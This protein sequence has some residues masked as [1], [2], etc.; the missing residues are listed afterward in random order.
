MSPWASWSRKKKKKKLY[1]Q[2]ERTC[3]PGSPRTEKSNK[4]REPLRQMWTKLLSSL[5]AVASNY[6]WGSLA[7]GA[8]PKLPSMCARPPITYLWL[9]VNPSS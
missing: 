7:A 6:S 9:I 1:S 4:E 3:K 2:M 5:K 8:E